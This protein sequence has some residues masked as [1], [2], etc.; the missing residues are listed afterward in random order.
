MVSL[1]LDLA[2]G[3][4]AVI[5]MILNALFYAL[6]RFFYKKVSIKTEK[7]VVVVTGCDSGKMV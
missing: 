3:I 4:V 5:I 7:H 1:V 6:E 2:A